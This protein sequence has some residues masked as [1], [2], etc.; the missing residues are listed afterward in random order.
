MAEKVFDVVPLMKD[1]SCD[2]CGE[3][4]M[5]PTGM[6]LMSSPAKYEHKCDKCDHTE[7]YLEQYPS[8][9]HVSPEQYRSIVEQNSAT[10]VQETN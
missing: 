6:A 5:R 7:S 4:F 8:V 9:I 10:E 2:V 3:G 1:Q